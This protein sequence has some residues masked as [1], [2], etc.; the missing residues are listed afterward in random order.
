[1]GTS[2]P[3]QPFGPPF[4]TAKPRIKVA[5]FLPGERVALAP[6]AAHAY[7]DATGTITLPAQA[8]AR[9]GDVVVFGPVSGTIVVLPPSRVDREQ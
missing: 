9:P 2:F 7:A 1:M 5:G 3:S 8:T 6:V 4:P